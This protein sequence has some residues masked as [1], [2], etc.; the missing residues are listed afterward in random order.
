METSMA[1]VTQLRYS[2]LGVSDVK[3]WERFATETLGL[4]V[5]GREADGTLFLRMDEYH[6][7]FIVHPRGKDGVA[8]I[9]WEVADEQTLHAMTDQLRDAGVAVQQGTPA[10]AEA[11]RVVGLIAFEGPNRIPSEAF[12]GPLMGFDHPFKSPR[13]ISGFETGVMGLG[14]IVLAVDDLDESLH[15]YRDVLGVRISDFSHRESAPGARHTMEFFI[16]T[17]ATTRWRSMRRE[18]PNGCST[19]CCS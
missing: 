13:A 10:Q 5:N 17:P 12:Y 6:H 14:H 8:Y 3:A 2:G 4:Q 19:S 9:G 1:N 11:H 15:F 16:V 18:T 7:R